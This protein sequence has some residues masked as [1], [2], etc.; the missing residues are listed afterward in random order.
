[1]SDIIQTIKEKLKE[2]EATNNVKILLACETGSRGWGFHSPDSDYDVRFIYVHPIDWY[3]GVNEKE[4]HITVPIND[5]LDITGW[6][7]RKSLQL[8]TKHNAALMERLQSPIIYNEVKNF[9]EEYFQIAKDNFSSI[10]VM[11]H[12]LSMSKSYYDKCTISEEIKLKNLFYCIRT[13]MAS[14]WIHNYK[15]VPPMELKK[16]M[17]LIENEKELVRRIG[18]L[19]I[20]KS[21][22]NESYIHHNEPLILDY[23]K[24]M[25]DMCDQSINALPGKKYD[26]ETLNTFLLK[27]VKHHDR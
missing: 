12:Y 25:I 17:P 2:I 7:L 6:E 18:E 1:M 23:I 21:G 8:L 26:T 9:K 20:I 16:L 24:R 5:E 15:T 11:H 4:D 27:Y 19:V 14:H 13:T 3:I 10:S 22:Q